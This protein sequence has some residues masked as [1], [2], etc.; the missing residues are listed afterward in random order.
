VFALSTIQVIVFCAK[1]HRVQAAAALRFS[2]D[3]AARKFAAQC[4]EV[5]VLLNQQQR[6]GA[7]YK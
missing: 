6:C 5:F 2:R 4:V 7:F 3:L 1:N